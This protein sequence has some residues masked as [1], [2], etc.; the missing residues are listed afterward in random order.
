V[1][2]REV[3]SLSEDGKSRKKKENFKYYQSE[4]SFLSKI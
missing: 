1:E 4:E 3:Q 2:E